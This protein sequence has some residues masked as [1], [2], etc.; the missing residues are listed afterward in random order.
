MSRMCRVTDA[1]AARRFCF[2]HNNDNNYND[3][4]NDN[5]RNRRLGRALFLCFVMVGAT[6]N[7]N[8]NNYNDNNNDNDRN[9]SVK[10]PAVRSVALRHGPPAADKRLRR[11]AAE[12]AAGAERAAVR[13][14]ANSR[15][16]ASR[17]A[18]ACVC[19]S[20]AR[21]FVCASSLHARVECRQGR[22]G[23]D[24]A[25]AGEVVGHEAEPVQLVADRQVAVLEPAD[26]I[27][28]K[29]YIVEVRQVLP[30]PP[31]PPL[32]PSPPRSGR[33]QA[34]FG[35]SEVT[36][37]RAPPDRLASGSDRAAAPPP[38]PSPADRIP[39]RRRTP[40]P[41]ATPRAE[42]F[43]PEPGRGGAPEASGPWY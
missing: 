26:P 25:D 22:P 23:A 13:P 36:R 12:F 21:A 2:G 29:L 11:R 33:D 17:R 9:F 7:N 15:H 20:R 19:V 30:R 10:I 27:I 34:G 18:C 6:A 4:N 40:R 5:D 31:P 32:P 16:P 28:Y 37:L 39:E 3:N 24:L 41:T 43:D 38:F 14:P 42:S 1:W 8:D 35:E